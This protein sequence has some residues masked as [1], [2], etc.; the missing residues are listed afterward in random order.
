MLAF[1]MVLISILLCYKLYLIPKMYRLT[2]VNAEIFVGVCML[3]L[4]L[5]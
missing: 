4:K 2:I 1:G 3:R 5:V